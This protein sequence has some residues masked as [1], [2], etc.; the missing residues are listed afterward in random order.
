MVFCNFAHASKAQNVVPK[1]KAGAAEDAS[2]AQ[3]KDAITVCTDAIADIIK[4]IHARTTI[5][6][7]FPTCP[8]SLCPDAI[9]AKCIRR[10]VEDD[11]RAKEACMIRELNSPWRQAS[12]RGLP[13][14]VA[15][16]PINPPLQ[17][18]C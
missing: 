4:S 6:N 13:L 17:P 10:E 15:A 1:I 9:L 18:T 2:P 5:T 11:Y 14:Q 7:V 8:P 3:Y 16:P 12:T